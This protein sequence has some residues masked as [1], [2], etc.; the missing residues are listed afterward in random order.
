MENRELVYGALSARYWNIDD[1]E[2][3]GSDEQ[4]IN[5]LKKFLKSQ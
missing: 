2:E 1:L 3:E 5:I 4:I